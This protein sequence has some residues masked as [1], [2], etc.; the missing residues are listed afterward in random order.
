MKD[1]EGNDYHALF[2]KG[3]ENKVLIYFAGGG[4]SINKETARDDTYNT[5]NGTTRYAGKY[6]DEYGRSCFRCRE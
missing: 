4:V 1:S 2:K 3:A 6:H 5:K